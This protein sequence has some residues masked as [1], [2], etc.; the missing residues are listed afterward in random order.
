MLQETVDAKWCTVFRLELSLFAPKLKPLI[1][2]S[3]RV[4]LILVHVLAFDVK[5][6]LPDQLRLTLVQLYPDQA[7]ESL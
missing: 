2:N 5:P 3:Y 6:C 7:F 4:M 1:V